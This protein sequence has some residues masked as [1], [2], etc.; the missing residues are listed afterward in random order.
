MRAFVAAILALCFAL[1]AQAAATVQGLSLRLIGQSAFRFSDGDISMA[2]ITALPEIKLRFGKRWRSQLIGRMD[3]SGANTGLGSVETFSPPSKPFVREDHVR[4]DIERAVLTWRKRYTRITL[5]KQSVAW[6]VLDGLQ[7]TDR[8]DAA[9]RREFVFT[10]IR[11]ERLGRWG[12]RARTRIAG[13]SV[14]AAA[15]FDPTVSQLALQGNAFDVQAPRFRAGIPVGGPDFRLV[16]SD[17]GTLLKNGTYGL[18][19]SKTF[20]PRTLSVLAIHGP[21]TD[22]VFQ[23]GQTANSVSLTYNNRTLI[24]ATFEQA[25]GPFIVRLEGAVIPDQDVNVISIAPLSV[26]Q[27]TR[28]LGGAGVDWRG[29]D[30]LLLNVQLGVDHLSGGP[31]RLV[32]PRSDIIST[33]RLQKPF[34]QETWLARIEA[35]SALTDGDGVV[36]PALEWQVSDLLRLLAGADV[37]FGTREGIFG[38]FRRQ[39]RLWF[40]AEFAL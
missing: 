39:S 13:I 21:D 24:G 36:R 7:V 22:P 12:V 25:A 1:P 30:G 9:R 11:P 20:G 37:I 31:E 26:S 29:S 28:V 35:I 32:R 23:S 4:L 38:Q 10:D 3:I 19:L 17:R 14:D 15:A 16:V 2:R 27:R 33:V 8:F 34:K 5:G 6:G 40:R 18:R